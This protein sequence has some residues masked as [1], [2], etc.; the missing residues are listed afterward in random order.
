MLFRDKIISAFPDIADNNNNNNNEQEQHTA[1]HPPH[2]ST[3][4]DYAAVVT[5]LHTGTITTIT[6]NDSLET[7]NAYREKTIADNMG[8][9]IVSKEVASLLKPNM[10]TQ[11]ILTAI[12]MVAGR[13]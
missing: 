12:E 11:N 3:A 5:D 4:L 7:L 13:R 10:P 1:K 6:G 2:Q 8:C 9:T